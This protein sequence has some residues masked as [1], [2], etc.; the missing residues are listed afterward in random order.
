MIYAA[1]KK[2]AKRT[3]LII[4]LIGLIGEPILASEL[5]VDR[6][7][8][9]SQQPTIEIEEK[10][11]IPIIDII[12]P[13]PGGVSH[14]VFKE[15]NVDEIGVVFNNNL[16]E[17]LGWDAEK[18]ILTE[19]PI[20]ANEHLA[21]Q[22]AKI[23]L[24]EVTGYNISKLLGI[25]EIFGQ[26]ADFILANPNG[27]YC[28]GAS[29]INAH[30]VTLTTGRPQLDYA[31][32]LR[33]LQVDR[34]T[35]EIHDKGV[36]I[37]L[38]GNPGSPVEILSRAVKI[39]G[40]L[41]T[42]ND[43]YIYTG[44]NKFDYNNKKLDHQPE[45]TS[46]NK[47]YLAIDGALVGKIGA[48]KI[49]IIATEQGVGV[50][51]P[52]LIAD[53]DNIEITVDGNIQ[54]KDIQTVGDLLVTS[55]SGNI[56]QKAEKNLAQKGCK[57]EAKQGAIHLSTQKFQVNNST[58]FSSKQLHLGPETELWVGTD[59]SCDVAL[60]LSVQEK[61]DNQGALYIPKLVVDT[62]ETFINRGRI[63]MQQD[64]KLESQTIYNQGEIDVKQGAANLIGHLHIHNK[65]TIGG[66]RELSLITQDM[67][68]NVGRL[69][70]GKSMILKSKIFQ[71][72]GVLAGEEE[73]TIVAKEQL[74]NKGI[75]SANSLLSLNTQGR[76]ENTAK[77]VSHQDIIVRAKSFQHQDTLAA[78]GSVRIVA[79]DQLTN[80]GNIKCKQEMELQAGHLTNLGN[81]YSQA[82]IQ[83][84]ET[85][86]I[87]NKGSL[88]TPGRLALTASKIR[89]EGILVSEANQMVLTAQ[90]EVVNS[91]LMVGKAQIVIETAGR[92]DN[93]GQV[94]SNKENLTITA[95]ELTNTGT[96]YGHLGQTLRMQELHNL[97]TINTDGNLLLD[98]VKVTNQGILSARQQLT[99]QANSLDNTNEINSLRGDAQLLINQEFINQKNA[100]VIT[101]KD[102][103]LKVGKVTNQGEIAASRSIKAI[104]EGKL[105]N[106]GIVKA[107]HHLI[108][109]ANHI[110]NTDQI[111]S[112]T[113]KAKLTTTQGLINQQ[114]AQVVSARA[115]TL[116]SPTLTNQGMIS[117]PRKL[118]LKVDELTNHGKIV[119]A[120]LTSIRF[121]TI[122]N[123]GVLKIRTDATLTSG[124]LKNNGGVLLVE[125]GKLTLTI[126]GELLNETKDQFQPLKKDIE[127]QSGTIY[128]KAA[129]YITADSLSNQ[130][131]IYSRGPITL[132]TGN[133]I[134]QVGI[135]HTD[136]ELN[137]ES[138]T[139]LD[140]QGSIT[141]RGDAKVIAQNKLTNT[142][143]L[144]SN[145]DIHVESQ[146]GAIENRG[147]ITA[148]VS[149]N[150]KAHGMITQSGIL[151]SGQELNITTDNNV[152]NAGT[153]QP[154]KKL[155][156][157]AQN[158]TNTGSIEATSATMSLSATKKINNSHQIISETGNVILKAQELENHQGGFMRSGS[159]LTINARQVTNQKEAT[160]ST[161]KYLE[162]VNTSKLVNAGNI[163]AFKLA[164]TGT[165]VVS[166]VDTGKIE[167]QDHLTLKSQ[168]FTNSGEITLTQGN[169]EITSQTDLTVSKGSIVTQQGNL[170]VT[171]STGNLRNTGG[172]LSSHQNMMLTAPQGEIENK[173]LIKSEDNLSIQAR[174][175]T[176]SGKIITKKGTITIKKLSGR[177]HNTNKIQSAGQLEVEVIACINEGNLSSAGKLNLQT[178]TLNNQH[179][180]HIQAQI[181]EIK[182]TDQ[183]V[184]AKEINAEQ[185]LT[186]Q[187]GKL[188]NTG[189]IQTNQVLTV[190]TEQGNLDNS[191]TISSEKG[192][193]TITVVTGTLKNSKVIK[194]YHNLTVRVEQ[195]LLENNSQ[196]I[197]EQQLD[198]RAQRIDNKGE[199]VG[200]VAAIITTTD[201]LTNSHIIGS[202]KDLTLNVG[203]QLKNT[204]KGK[205]GQVR[206][207]LKLNAY[208]LHNEG[209][210]FFS[211]ASTTGSLD[212]LQVTDFIYNQGAIKASGGLHL[213]AL[214]RIENRGMI[215]AE[216]NLG[217]K[218][219]TIQ[220][221]SGLI[222]SNQ[223][224]LRLDAT[225][226]LYNADIL[227]VCKGTLTITTN[228]LDNHT[229]IKLDKDLILNIQN[230]DNSCTIGA[231]G[232]FQL[233]KLQTLINR[234]TG[235]LASGKG[236]N[237][238]AIA[239]KLEN[240]GKIF[241][242]GSLSIQATNV[243]IVNKGEL[244]ANRS[245]ILAAKSLLNDH[246]VQGGGTTQLTIAEKIINNDSIAS[247]S[248]LEIK[249]RALGIGRSNAQP[250]IQANSNIML[251]VGE[252]SANAIRGG[253]GNTN[254][255][256]R[257]NYV[258]LD[259]VS[260]QGNLSITSVQLDNYKAIV[261]GKK[262]EI[263][264][265]QIINH[266]GA[267]LQGGK[268]SS[269]LE[270]KGDIHNSG[271][272]SSEENLLVQTSREVINQGTLQATDSLH[273]IAYS[274][275]NS[276]QQ[277]IFSGKSIHIQATHI[278][279]NQGDIF[280]EGNIILEGQ[281]GQHADK[282]SN[283]TDDHEAR[284]E[285]MGDITIR[286][287]ELENKG[288]VL[289]KDTEIIYSDAGE[290]HEADL[291]WGDPVCTTRGNMRTDTKVRD[292]CYDKEDRRDG[293]YYTTT[294]RSK[295]L[296]TTTKAEIVSHIR[297]SPAYL[298]ARKN[299]NLDII[300]RVNNNDSQILAGGHI[301]IG[302]NIYTTSILNDAKIPDGPYINN[303]TYQTSQYL[304]DAFRA[305]KTWTHTEW[306]CDYDRENECIREYI[307]GKIFTLPAV[308]G[309]TIRAGSDLNINA[310]EFQ[311]GISVK[312][313]NV[314]TCEDPLEKIQASQTISTLYSVEL[315]KG[316]YGLF[317]LQKKPDE[318]DSASQSSAIPQVQV[319]E[320]KC[321]V[322]E[323]SSMSHIDT[324]MDIFLAETLVFQE[325]EFDDIRKAA[326][327]ARVHTTLGEEKIED[328]PGYTP[329]YNPNS[330]SRY[331]SSTAQATDPGVPSY[332]SPSDT[333]LFTEKVDTNTGT[334]YK[335]PPPQE[336]IENHFLPPL[337]QSRVKVDQAQYYGSPYFL[338]HVGLDPG[339]HGSPNKPFRFL[340]DPFY[341]SRLIND[342]IY[343]Q[344]SRPFLYDD[345]ATPEEQVK[346]LIDHTAEV[347]KD[348]KL[349]FGVALSK[350]QI[351]SLKKDILWYV[352]E[353]VVGQKVLVPQIYL[354]QSTIDNLKSGKGTGIHSGGDMNIKVAGAMT[355]TGNIS[356]KGNQ[357]IRAESLRNESFGNT[358]AVITSEG[359]TDVET[360]NNLENISGKISGKQGLK[361]V[362]TEGQ[363]HN[364]TKLLDE[365]TLGMQ[366]SLETEGDLTVRAK[367]DIIN[368]A[369]KI[370]SKGNA[371][372]ISETGDLLNLTQTTKKT[373]TESSGSHQDGFWDSEHKTSTT[374]HTSTEHAVSS[375]EI[376]K[377]LTMKARDI[378]FM[379]T[380]VKVGGKADMKA[381][382]NFEALAVQDIE[383]TSTKTEEH[384][385]ER[386]LF[387][388]KSNSK[389]SSSYHKKATSKGPNFEIGE[390]F[391]VI[392]G[393]DADFE[394]ANVNAGS[395][396]MDVQGKTTIRKAYNEETHESSNS[397]D[398]KK[399]ALFGLI[400]N[401]KG[402]TTKNKKHDK[403][404][405]GNNW[406]VRHNF[407]VKG[408][409]DVI[410]Q[411]IDLEAHQIEIRSTEGKV[412]DKAV[413]EIHKDEEETNNYTLKQGILHDNVGKTQGEQ[414][415]AALKLRE[416]IEEKKLV[417]DNNNTAQSSTFRTIAKIV[418]GEDGKET[419]VQGN[420]TFKSDKQK[421]ILEATQTDIR[422]KLSLQGKEGV[423]I[424]EKKE[425][426]EHTERNE[427]YTEELSIGIKNSI[428]AAVYQAKAVKEAADQL[429]K[430][431]AA[432]KSYCGQL[433]QAKKLLDQR[434]LTQ[435]E[436]DE[437][438][439]EGKYHLAA[440]SAATL[441][442]ATKTKQFTSTAAQAV[443]TAGSNLGFSV[444]LQ[445]DINKTVD[446]FINYTER[447]KGSDIKTQELEVI[448]EGTLKISGSKIKSKKTDI[449]ARDVL[450]EAFKGAS[451]TKNNSTSQGGNVTLDLAPSVTAPIS[452]VGVSLHHE[453]TTGGSQGVQHTNS[454]LELGE[455]K[456]NIKKDLN[457]IGGQ[458]KTSSL[459]GEVGGNIHIETVANK[460]EGSQNKVGAN[461][462]LNMGLGGGA[463]GSIGQSMGGSYGH[464]KESSNWVEQTSGLSSTE[465]MHLKVGGKTK[466]KG[467][468]LGSDSGQMHLE[469][470]KIEYEDINGHK[471]SSGFDLSGGVNVSKG[472]G[473]KA[474]L[475]EHASTGYN[476]SYAKQKISSSLG[477]GTVIERS[478]HKSDIKRGAAKSP[479]SYL[480]TKSEMKV[481]SEM[482]KLA[483]DPVKA[484][485][486]VVEDSKILYNTGKFAAK[487]VSE[488]RQN[489]LVGT[490]EALRVGLAAGGAAIDLTKEENATQKLGKTATAEEFEKALN[491]V[492]DDF[493]NRMGVKNTANVKLY[494]GEDAN[495]KDIEYAKHNASFDEKSN[496]INY[497]TSREGFNKLGT[498]ADDLAHESTHKAIS[499]NK[500]SK[501]HI[502][503]K[504]EEGV[505]RLV[506]EH[507]R[508]MAESL[509][510]KSKSQPVMNGREWNERNKDSEIL[511]DNKAR[512]AKTDGSK[513]KA[514]DLGQ[515]LAF[516][517]A[518]QAAFVGDVERANKII[519]GQKEL[520]KKGTE[521]AG[522]IIKD[523][524][525]YGVGF[526]NA[527]GHDMFGLKLDK[528][529][530]LFHHKGQQDGHKA[531]ILT[532]GAEAGV[533]GFLVKSSITATAVGAGPTGGLIVGATAPTAA[534][535]GGL[536]LHGIFTAKR[537]HENIGKNHSYSFTE[538]KQ[539]SQSSGDKAIKNS[540]GESVGKGGKV[541][542]EKNNQNF[543]KKGGGK[544]ASHA[545]PRK[546]EAARE[547]YERAK[548][549]Y[550]EFKKHSGLIK[551]RK[552]EL[553][554]L[555]DKMKHFK[556]ELDFIGETHSRNAKGNK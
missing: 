452:G 273:V 355:N 290:Y 513:V 16:N 82:S 285:A 397:T 179:T 29:F 456:L 387:T 40:S 406:K 44:L 213:E 348:L 46:N 67:L 281:Q 291:S 239:S 202:A 258:C 442:L 134:L 461:V 192:S 313:V 432:H 362:S 489:G 383:E 391:K 384:K 354:T 444:D 188:D 79:T 286:A 507:A 61:I 138:G 217:L 229:D 207:Q 363:I 365:S 215:V 385:K 548:V 58:Q 367:G 34:G 90:E 70:S 177:L 458:V 71:H 345:V 159:R 128:A 87:A 437:V 373:S 359:T 194:S 296:F 320:I 415:R 523:G 377:N 336:K 263:R 517:P 139:T 10:S 47:P 316:D 301:R 331:P 394:G 140:N 400:K 74:T 398:N 104:V 457:I 135:L 272:I 401:N 244:T 124:S 448:T 323:A 4:A 274:V 534:L 343:K 372:I 317:K 409:E 297:T 141:A 524:V 129:Q 68:E 144:S 330:H 108:L 438:A 447:A 283:I 241:T 190:T 270:S 476:R 342:A 12:K 420:A 441:D 64:L 148:T 287:K 95:K 538:G 488:V 161:S 516:D 15:Y 251:E 111:R 424:I 389:S 38:S 187:A 253:A 510:N 302:H 76:L 153:I 23:I 151:S 37:P 288:E 167:L 491:E 56:E 256:I 405:V 318:S 543:N 7:A 553:Q 101:E 378:T 541:G 350:E 142:G 418:K 180:G 30:R 214:K 337:F 382:R 503:D 435:E 25:T 322:F 218:A 411:G 428:V 412:L 520:I 370:A 232:T 439:A 293:L 502:S 550:E 216:K 542:G 264:A 237:R 189:K 410:T 226:R 209:E 175:L 280:T 163:Q 525:E 107:E 19:T 505:A 303:Q 556:Q 170:C 205:I 443:T 198:L 127:Q 279:N 512:L 390:E 178:T 446:E 555:K 464:S 156:I 110:E 14:N 527:L 427:K 257:G 499:E 481:D 423:E 63:I 164:H 497:N 547:N 60:K 545:N 103:V 530:S 247:I 477:Q 181:A 526:G 386:G 522:E 340:G 21:G 77:L 299:L 265:D 335:T 429:D 62:L 259:S 416:K 11:G 268:G 235:V 165:P 199:M 152:S 454:M 53:V 357:T 18:S 35:I 465:A 94:I 81:I 529:R 43:L 307:I 356:S 271:Q 52:P 539:E 146:A 402:E 98:A 31:G 106:K 344:T 154:I 137:L 554:K 136:G 240:Y 109:Q 201:S 3:W 528:P 41:S 54:L 376:G 552:K 361:V 466:L 483:V 149:T 219:P 243:D 482:V 115:L 238:L 487:V 9:C 549:E 118:N 185:N 352:E 349:S 324:K 125:D 396:N 473:A 333:D 469:T 289:S 511:K 308:E 121:Q 208:S 249:A 85:N 426:T 521:A 224:D 24:A 96:L 93:Q 2:F 275:N 478:G 358:Q 13:S 83:V 417:K 460:Q 160:I 39:S 120:S 162:L 17:N 485:K 339:Q 22:A 228:H 5:E 99:I 300:D 295:C 116:H 260:S 269:R 414:G 191:G 480:D 100:K 143:Q 294:T 474:K 196:F 145:Q 282:V 236:E 220:H 33:S 122:R 375:I 223:G 419:I 475:R 484:G 292:Y 404:G 234:S 453:Q 20:H 535:G 403:I 84:K 304:S 204:D 242:K 176:N 531:A 112:Q 434:E 171:A 338:R 515:M 368:K 319:G 533:G 59:T 501:R 470:E 327:I 551:N 262:L 155:D 413:E 353:E 284:I 540:N 210:L 133:Q 315:P 131:Q 28:N 186:I 431:I 395:V 498:I 51:C 203:G 266:L 172:S 422:G 374:T 310:K 425:T 536:L 184:N 500:F 360:K 169:L 132:N 346:C 212:T 493:Q 326:E 341:E 532:A 309:S 407:K 486:E 314:A 197:A 492:G 72:Q 440:I 147:S 78:E 248:N 388:S 519:E 193:G 114:G 544:N 233:L 26:G 119:T 36:S 89:N 195:G 245:L 399:E 1:F 494:Q 183:L 221:L 334:C 471:K 463:I 496:T 117:V 467:A 250:I 45:P 546:R 231:K 80:G 168:S 222:Q 86:T 449:E 332:N 537:A 130:G 75:I 369:G 392:A 379:G 48:R 381:K 42:Q 32:V 49:T 206:G 445:G 277:V 329:N 182:V 459:T 509:G 225:T 462:G 150:L 8:P 105:N 298:N 211:P 518:A 57:L 364:T 69:V 276:P 451:S 27:I 102:L 450:V 157:Q 455:T 123:T 490:V 508:N 380:D 421:V 514:S 246:L 371:E 166:N 55:Q 255:T 113:G 472:K 328:L 311:N 312:S 321:P 88:Q 91:N 126:D 325:P 278:T 254:L 366:A 227:N 433:R 305:K 351:N 430:A 66:A 495:L 92:V 50:N 173:Q 65:G 408:K 200:R 506:G 504:Q 393:G 347:T 73:V 158:I 261:A 436:Y 6:D 306:C 174:N 468:H 479:L 252:L 267:D 97:K 230:L